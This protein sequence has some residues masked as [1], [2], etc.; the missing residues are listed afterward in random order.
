MKRSHD[1]RRYVPDL[2]TVLRETDEAVLE[3]RRRRALDNPELQQAA[4]ELRKERECERDEPSS[5]MLDWGRLSDARKRAAASAVATP[6]AAPPIAKA[7]ARSDRP[8]SP[9]QRRAPLIV[10]LAAVS[11]A[12][13]PAVMVFLVFTWQQP[14]DP[15]AAERASAMEARGAAQSDVVTAPAPPAVEANAARTVEDARSA[16]PPLPSGERPK[17][18]GA[19]RG[20][21]PGAPVPVSTASPVRAPSPPEGL[22]P[23][24]SRWF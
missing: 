11:A 23:T 19:R 14:Q 1:I 24:T 7:A 8:R 16:T 2:A 15:P 12:L 22:P 4:A 6:G 3:E 10:M 20:A 17:R 18:A 13:L 5:P 21:P 9:R